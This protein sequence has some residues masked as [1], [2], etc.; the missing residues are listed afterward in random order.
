EVY[1]MLNLL[2]AAAIGTSPTPAVFADRHRIGRGPSVE[3]WTNHDE[4]FR[5][6]EQARVYFRAS[7]SGYVTVF[8]IDTDGRMRVLYPREPWEDNYARA[9]REY[10]VRSY[11]DRYAFSVDDYPGEGYI[12]AVVSAD[13]FNF[14]VLARGDHWDYRVITADGGRV[15]GDP[16]V[17]LTDLVDRIVPPN[18]D[19]YSYDVLPYY[20]EQH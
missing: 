17:A 5:R 2:L 7:E 10:E 3:V 1:M 16:Y 20:V 19:E 6:G 14:G 11:G 15:T 8:R 12:F 4:V 9:G 18:Y 13:A